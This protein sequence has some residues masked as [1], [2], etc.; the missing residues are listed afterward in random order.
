M[1]KLHKH[2]MKIHSHH[3]LLC[4]KKLTIKCKELLKS[5]LITIP[6]SHQM[7]FSSSFLNLCLICLPIKSS[8]VTGSNF[9]VIGNYKLSIRICFLTNHNTR[10]KS[11][12]TIIIKSKMLNLFPTS[13]ST[14]VTMGT[15]K[16]K[17]LL[18]FS[19]FAKGCCFFWAICQPL[20]GKAFKAYLFLHV[21]YFV[22]SQ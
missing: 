20:F 3:N 12:F 11:F 16:S 21:I 7:S 6:C 13:S 1:L 17:S 19:F 18:G 22:R 14:D 8:C 4:Q 2:L 10:K 15:F 5:L 9:T